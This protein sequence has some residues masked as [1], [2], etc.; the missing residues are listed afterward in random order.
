MT[1][2]QDYLNVS[3][4]VPSSLGVSCGGEGRAGGGSSLCVQL[5]I[6]WTPQTSEKVRKRETDTVLYWG[7]VGAGETENETGDGTLSGSAGPSVPSG[8]SVARRRL[9]RVETDGD[10]RVRGPGR[11]S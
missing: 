10:V 7:H 5:L 6:R 8:S 9:T 3:S 4:P 2:D 1:G 11:S